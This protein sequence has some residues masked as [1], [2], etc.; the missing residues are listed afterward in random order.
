MFVLV[1]LSRAV[2]RNEAS[3]DVQ[4]KNK[5]KRKATKDLKLLSFGDDEEAFQEEV[6]R[7]AST[8][9]KKAKTMA[10]SHDLLDDHKLKAKVDAEVLQRVAEIDNEVASEDKKTRAREKLK[11]AVAAAS[12]KNA[13]SK[14]RENADKSLDTTSVNKFYAS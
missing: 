5:P 10:S 1:A 3:N 13:S 9:H 14:E 7:A 12:S 4:A 11:V 6:S 8:F 2:K